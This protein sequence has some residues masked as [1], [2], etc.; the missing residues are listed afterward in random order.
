MGLPPPSGSEG[1]ALEEVVAQMTPQ[2]RVAIILLDALGISTW[3]FAADRMPNFTRLAEGKLL[4]LRS[5][6]PCSTPVCLASI[7]TGASPEAHRVRER[8]DE[9]EVETV[10]ALIRRA[11]MVSAVAGRRSSSTGLLLARYSDRAFLAPSNKDEEVEHK[12]LL[13]IEQEPAFVFVQLLDIDN[14]GHAHGPESEESLAAC[15]RTDAR[16]GRMLS[17]VSLRGYGS[18]IMADHGQHTVKGANGSV[19]GTHDGSTEEDMIVPLT[20]QPAGQ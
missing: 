6:L 13:C 19:R 11:G 2:K 7:I 8:T 14:A 5:V 15:Q 1:S 12:L 10:F 18:V 16:M 20:W 3:Q 4:A 9:I 17:A